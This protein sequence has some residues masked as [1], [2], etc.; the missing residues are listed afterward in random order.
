MIKKI[1]KENDCENC[2][3]SWEDKG[4]EGEVYAYGCYI[5][6]IDKACYVPYL[7]RIIRLYFKKRKIN[8]EYNKY[9]DTLKNI[10]RKVGDNYV[11]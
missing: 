4:Y 9:W 5:R 2:P 6:D 1:L 10:L 7:I 8:K 3:C 11:K